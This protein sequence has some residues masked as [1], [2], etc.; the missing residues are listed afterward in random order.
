VGLALLAALMLAGGV[1]AATSMRLASAQVKARMKL[2]SGLDPSAPKSAH[3][4]KSKASTQA[5]KSRPD[6]RSLPIGPRLS[7]EPCTLDSC[8]E[9][10]KRA[11][12]GRKDKAHH[13]NKDRH[14]TAR[15]KLHKRKAHK[16]DV[17]HGHHGHH[18]RP[19]HQGH[20]F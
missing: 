2:A 18:S 15:D 8:S 13:A 16:K 17:H 5:E 9:H 14:H 3:G 19:G 6:H 7:P 11:P 20:T 10:A 1:S 4:G 12:H